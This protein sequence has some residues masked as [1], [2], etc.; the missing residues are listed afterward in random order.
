MKSYRFWQVDAFSHEPYKGNPAA[1]VFEADPLSA[2]QMQTIARQMNL[3][4]T[5]FFCQPTD[6]Q[7]DYRAR[8]FTVVR[9]IPFAGHPTIASAFAHTT[10]HEQPV[11]RNISLQQECG[12]GII[13]VKVDADKGPLFT[14]I[15][16][17]RPSI[18]SGLKAQKLASM[19]GCSPADLSDDPTEVCSIGSPWLIARIRTLAALQAARPDLG[20]IEQVCREL[21]AVGLTVYSMAAVHPECSL[22]VRSFAPGAGIAE[23]PVC[24]SGNGAVAVHVAEHSYRERTAFSYRAEQGLEIHRRGIL[25]LS[26]DRGDDGTELEVG[27]GGRA[28]KVMEGQLWI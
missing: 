21:G 15:A 23:D 25:H 12:A 28:V 24:G 4:E 18:F 20:V 14:L 27:L 5:V 19:L 13:P 9:E 3:S 11:G 26:V 2:E 1:I 10:T 7:A 22:H 8:I 17:S 16:A 6:P